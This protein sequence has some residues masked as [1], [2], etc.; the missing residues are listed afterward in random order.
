MDKGAVRCVKC[1]EEVG[2][3]NSVKYCSLHCQKLY[4]KARWKKR[5]H[6]HQ[7]E[8]QRNY[9]RAKNGGNRPATWP[10]K[11]RDVECLKCGGTE[12]LQGAHIKPLWAGGRHSHIVT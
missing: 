7:L 1:G 10:A 2:T 3:R 12:D 6:A 8:Y 9:R 5:T 4:L 11:Y